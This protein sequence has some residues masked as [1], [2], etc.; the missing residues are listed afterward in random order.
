MSFFNNIHN[1]KEALSIKMKWSSIIILSLLFLTGIVYFFYFIFS[2]A[3][4]NQMKELKHSWA[5]YSYDEPDF[6]FDS[7][8]ISYI[9]TVG[10]NETFVMETTLKKD[11][12]E[13]N[14]LIKGNHQWLTVTLG[15]TLLYQRKDTQKETNPGLSLAVIDLPANYIGKKLKITVSSPYEN[16][17]G[18]PPKVYIG[19]TGPMISF[20]FSQS[21]PQVLTM[22]IA[23]F[24]AI[25]ILVYTIYV[26][27]SQ[28]K[29]DYSLIILSCFALTLGL[30]SVS[31][32]ILSGVLFEPIVH[33]FLSHVFIILTSVFIITYYFSKMIYYKKWYGLF[34]FVQISV[35]IGILVYAAVTPNEL[36]ELMPI[37]NITSVI[38]T[39]VTSLACIGEA[40]KD[41][42][43]FVACTPWIVLIAIIHCLI[44]IQ[45]AL[46]IYQ[47]TINW[48]TILY[49]IILI[50]IIGYN[51]IDYI[52]NSDHHQKQVDFL[53]IKTDLLEQHYEQLRQHIQ[54]ISTLRLDFIHDMENLEMLMYENNHSEAQNYLHKMLD[55]AQKFEVISSISGH[56]LTNLILARYREIAA[57][58]NIQVEFC[59]DLPQ[60][61]H[62]KDDDLAQLLIHVLEHSFR[63]THAIEN[64]LQRKI[65]LSMHEKEE[66]LWIQC[67]HS[68]HYDSNIFTR[69]ITE[70]LDDQEQYDLMMI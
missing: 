9:P 57:K 50:V 44:Y 70:E 11:L 1:K 37:A 51:I 47:T 15:D 17:S 18:I 13:A 52:M 53:Q 10:K 40:Y 36:P 19:T 49:I 30:E 28:K 8:Y 32:D 24:L 62:V 42:R 61:L 25:G 4:S 7:K 54:E 35:F 16:Y 33:S 46:G 5:F 22:V 12:D 41:N 6:K 14:L 27:Y 69:G 20:I 67:E 48:S 60:H 26:M 43:F 64:P 31:E 29:L 58:R 63:E 23:V 39:L 59:A 2:P 68:A 56:Q 65:Y 45:S 55:G 66:E 38:S 21:V 34:C 3:D